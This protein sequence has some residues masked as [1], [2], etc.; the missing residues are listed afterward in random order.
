MAENKTDGTG[1]ILACAIIIGIAGCEAKGVLFHNECYKRGK[2]VNT[3][4]HDSD[5]PFAV[6][7]RCESVRI[8]NKYWKQK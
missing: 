1:L 4:S 2:V 6:E 5:L 7:D 3:Y 8:S